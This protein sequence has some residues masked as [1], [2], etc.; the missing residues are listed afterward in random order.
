M[1]SKSNVIISIFKKWFIFILFL[2]ICF[3]F[4]T[5]KSL[6]K[7]LNPSL[8]II[9]IVALAFSVYIEKTGGEGM[10]EEESISEE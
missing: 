8:I 4:G 1:P 10:K 9:F 3:S 7:F 2:L 5:T 6:V